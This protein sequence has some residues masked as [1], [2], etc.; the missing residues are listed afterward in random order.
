MDDFENYISAIDFDYDSEDDV[1]TGYVYKTNTPQFN[2]VKR[3]VHAKVTKYMQETVEYRVQNCYIP[4]SVHRFIKCIE[5]FTNK[6][7]T[8]EVLTVI[9]SKKYQ[10]R[11]MTTARVQPFRRKCN[12][13][14]G[15]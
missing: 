14:I 9:Q 15:C 6:D 10:S 5:Y 1:F 13:N 3:G 12:I 8:E 7:Y 4:T 2:V 11:V